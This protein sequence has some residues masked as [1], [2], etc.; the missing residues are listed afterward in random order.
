MSSIEPAVDI[1]T[2]LETPVSSNGAVAPTAPATEPGGPPSAP[3]RFSFSSLARWESGLVVLVV[4][5]IIFGTSESGNFLTGTNFFDFGLNIGA[6]AIMA[7]PLTLIVMVGEIDLSVASVLGL[8][9]SLLGYLFSHGWPIEGAM[10]FVL[11]IGLVCGAF[12]GFLVTR[13]GLPSLAVTIGTLTLYR[14]IATII[15]G[16]NTITGFPTAFTNAGVNSLWGTQV[17]WTL[18]IFIVLAVVFGLVLHATPFGRSLYAIGL[19]E[20]TAYFSGIRVKRIKFGLFTLSGLIC[21]LVGIVWTFQYATASS[22]AG[23]GLELVVVTIVLF[24]GVSIFGGRGTIIGVVM[25]VCVLGGIDSALTLVNVSAQVQSIVTGI[26][27]LISVIL[28][29]AADGFGQLRA[30]LSRSG[31][32]R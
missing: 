6:I 13:L 26:L 28:P 19:H 25:A 29:N 27:L 4:A 11:V 22:D 20:E 2:A 24:G 30:R 9:C 21:S 31:A 12:N 23:L 17:S 16:S 7:L 14:G 8:S 3:Q 18:G 32:N 10:A 1:A 15:L 5:T